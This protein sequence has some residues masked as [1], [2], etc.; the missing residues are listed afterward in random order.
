MVST[1]DH[2]VGLGRCGRGQAVF[3]AQFGAEPVALSADLAMK[4][5]DRRGE[6]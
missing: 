4:K 5:A 1:I 6:M 3:D 2:A